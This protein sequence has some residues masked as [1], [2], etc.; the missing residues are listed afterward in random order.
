[1]LGDPVAQ[2]VD[3]RRAEPEVLHACNDH[4]N[5]RIWLICL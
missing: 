4:A 1:M 2:E 3:S 5:I